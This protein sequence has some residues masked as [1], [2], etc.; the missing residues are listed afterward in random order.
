MTAKLLTHR[1]KNKRFGW[2]V[3]LNNRVYR[4]TLGKIQVFCKCTKCGTEKL[5]R[6]N[7][8]TRKQSF[9]CG[10]SRFPNDTPIVAHPYLG[11]QFGNWTVISNEERR[12]KT[13]HVYV[14]CRC[15]CSKKKW[16]QL[17]NLKSGSSTSCGCCKSRNKLATSS[18]LN[19][20][21]GNWVVISNKLHR[22]NSNNIKLYCRCQ[23]CNTRKLI[24]LASLRSGKSQSCGCSILNQ[25][26]ATHSYLNKR[27][28]NW[29]VISKELQTNQWNQTQ[30][31]CECQV[32]KKTRK[33]ITLS[34]IKC[35]RSKS[36]GCFRQPQL[37]EK[38]LPITK[39]VAESMFKLGDR[40]GQRTIVSIDIVRRNN[41]KVILTQCECGKLEYI[42]I[43]NLRQCKSQRCQSC[44]LKLA[45]E[46]LQEKQRMLSETPQQALLFDI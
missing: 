15:R 16:V 24:D 43:N 11:Q 2:W 13:N 44:Q 46:K 32:C 38:V 1:Y 41:Q 36:C 6:L 18:Y 10:C 45:R 20:Q 4:D 39:P 35:G 34:I 14:Y 33:W 19:Q 12:S 27:F 28:G 7:N 26:I 21:F 8:L 17:N 29:L 25:Q 37:N 22:G 3:V 42:S 31:Y 9:S 5:V 40:Y 23:L 30:V